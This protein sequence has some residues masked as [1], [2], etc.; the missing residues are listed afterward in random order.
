MA[1]TRSK[2]TEQFFGFCTDS[3]R[4]TLIVNPCATPQTKSSTNMRLPETI[5]APPPVLHPPSHGKPVI[6]ATLHPKSLTF[7]QS[8]IHSGNLSP[9]ASRPAASPNDWKETR[10]CAALVGDTVSPL[11]PTNRFT[12]PLDRT[13]KAIMV[14]ARFGK[15]GEMRL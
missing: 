4:V 1:R 11:S 13:R 9:C 6:M 7:G 8:P 12:T 2:I 15:T 3:H 5:N 10:F 14:R